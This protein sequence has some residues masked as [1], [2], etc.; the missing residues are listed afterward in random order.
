MR[1][2]VLFS[3]AFNAIK[4]NKKRSILTML[5]IIIGIGAVIAIISIGQGFE[6]YV[7]DELTEDET[8]EITS[9]IT[10]QPNDMS[11]AYD[12]NIKFFSAQDLIEIRKIK[13]VKNVE[14]AG[15]NIDSDSASMILETDKT[16]ENTTAELV[17]NTDKKLVEGRNLTSVDDKTKNRVVVISDYIAKKLFEDKNSYLGKNVKINGLNYQ[18]VGVYKGATGMMA[19]MDYSL[20]IPKNTYEFYNESKFASTSI[21]LSLEKGA[22]VS[23]VSEK[24]VDFLADNGSMKNL[25]QYTFVDIGGLM[26]GISNILDSITTFIALIGGISLLIAGI[27]IM[28]MMFISVSE[29]TKEIG[30]RRALGATK[31]N[32]TIQFLLEGVIITV[33][34]GILGYFFG[35]I[36]AMI[37]AMFLPF[38]ISIETGPVLVS[39][40]I[41]LA[42]GIIFSY[43]PAKAAA[44]K[45]VIEILA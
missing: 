22:Q 40:F 16:T 45:N 29:R 38:S 8:Q 28:N 21:T 18:I 2:S 14:I 3:D 44:N 17:K 43:S 7:V 36:F 34:G 30:I 11:L 23:D 25:G 32:I 4:R 9:N 41:S 10:F 19:M 35:L 37:I 39:L 24:V 5:G 20:S 15:E 26:D 31:K 6:N 27:G 1:F 33:I 12:S 42:I 13:G